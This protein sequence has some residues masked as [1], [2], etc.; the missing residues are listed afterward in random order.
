[1]TTIKFGT[2]GWRGVIADDFTLPNA[3]IVAQAIARYV[4]RGEDA[5]EACSIGYDHRI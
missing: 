2:D 3:R 4:V 5:A 1:M